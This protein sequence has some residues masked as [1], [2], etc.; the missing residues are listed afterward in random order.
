MNAVACSSATRYDSESVPRLAFDIR[1]AS[2]VSCAGVAII[3]CR[4]LIGFAASIGRSSTTVGSSRSPDSVKLVGSAEDGGLE[5]ADVVEDS[6]SW[7]P[8]CEDGP[9]VLD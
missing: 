3:G 2:A 9:P 6:D 5:L 7:E 1:I 4:S 8:G